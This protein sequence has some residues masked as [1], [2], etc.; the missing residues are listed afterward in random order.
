MSKA[1]EKAVKQAVDRAMSLRNKPPLNTISKPIK[2]APIKR[3]MLEQSTA[4][5]GVAVGATRIPPPNKNK[6]SKL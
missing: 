6:K 3:E 1:L 5:G 2:K 4:C